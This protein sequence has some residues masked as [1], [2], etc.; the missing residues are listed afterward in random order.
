MGG[1]SFKLHEIQSVKELY[2]KG[3]KQKEIAEKLGRSTAGIRKIIKDLGIENEPVK[4]GLP[5]PSR[6]MLTSADI[7]DALTDLVLEKFARRMGVRQ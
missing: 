5:P 1:T 6:S 3:A 4:T 7:V 2:S